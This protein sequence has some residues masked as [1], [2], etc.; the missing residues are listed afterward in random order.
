VSAPTVSA[1]RFATRVREA[2]RRFA[3]HEHLGAALLF[4]VFVL[5]YLWPVLVG[6]D[7]LSS[8]SLLFHYPPWASSAPDGW[9]RS[10]NFIAADVPG[11]YYPFHVLARDLL[12]HGTFPVWSPHAYAGVPFFANPQTL[13]L[14]PFA[15]PI[16]VLP[17]ELGIAVSAAVKLWLAAFGTYLLVR[18][19]RLGFW[20]GVLAGASFGFSAW[21]VEWLSWE[22]LTAVSAMLPWALLL[23]ERILRSGRP[24]GPALGLALVSVLVFTGGHPGAIVHVTVAAGLYALI[25]AATV[26]GLVGWERVR[27]FGLG[28][29]ALALGALVCAVLLVPVLRAGA[30]TIGVKARIGLNTTI[31]GSQLPFGAIRT[32]LF[33]DWW[34]RPSDLSVAGPAN[35]N[36][37]TFFAGS[38]AMIFGLVALVSPGAWRRKAPF[39]VLAFIGLAVPLHVPVLFWLATHLPLLGQ[40]QFQRMM[41][42]FIFAMAVL[43]A[44]GLQRLIDAPGELRRVWVVLGAGLL[45]GVVALTGAGVSGADL[46]HAAGNVLHLRHAVGGLIAGT[47]VN[48]GGLIATSVVWWLIVVAVVGLLVLVWWR[49]PGARRV[50]V[51][52]LVAFAVLDVSYFAHDYQPMQPLAKVDL[53]ATGAIRYLQ[54]RRDLGRFTGVGGAA[55]DDWPAIYGLRDVRGSEPPQPSVRWYDLW[56][57][58]VAPEQLNWSQALM[59]MPGPAGLNAL[60]IMGARYIIDRPGIAAPRDLPQLS[61]GYRGSDATV[62]VNRDALPRAFV[63]PHVVLSADERETIATIGETAFKPRSDVVVER[64]EPDAAVLARSTGTGGKVRV[65]AE[66]NTSATLDAALRR[67][68]LVVLD[69]SLEQG[70]SVQVD[71]RPA[72]VVRADDVMRGVA[73]PAG[74]HRVI[75]SYTVPGLALGAALSALGLVLLAA[76]GLVFLR[77]GPRRVS[78]STPPARPARPRREHGRGVG[79]RPKWR[80]ALP[81]S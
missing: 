21:N 57:A 10:T 13:I 9:W 41:L 29:G 5:V 58:L 45:V 55:F 36:E 46:G 65:V 1:D 59:P 17:L 52:A 33:P 68:G 70:W 12:R 54:Q 27:R 40:V 48:A 56:K 67:P 77:R 4:C 6:G 51:V 19:L 25:R 72:K 23:I 49:R 8:R 24:L 60:S 22:T 30:G 34:G 7:V 20:P 63:A 32:V 26:P 15:W 76:G 78:A 11:S 47:D 69:D 28:V 73:V 64:G 44:F 62:L 37:R 74:R 38:V 71:G 80:R 35:Y 3:A 75:W 31:P 79:D 50:V 2:A 61:V 16:W 18:E 42:L 43:G 66:T 53:K 81:R 14:S 39:A